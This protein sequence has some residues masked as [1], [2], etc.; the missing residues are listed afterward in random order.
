[1]PI[2]ML[3]VN[4]ALIV[5]LLSGS[6]VLAQQPDRMPAK[7]DGRQTGGV[8]KAPAAR[9]TQS[10]I[11]GKAV[12]SDAT[13]LPNATVRLRN[14]T[15]NEIEQVTATD[16]IGE[17]SFTVQPNLPY[18]VEVVDQAGRI[19]AVGNVITTQAGEVASAVVAIPTRLPTLAG[20]FGDTTASVVSAAAG[21]GVTL[22]DTAILPVLSATR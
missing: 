1:M 11:H 12:D 21:T 4:L 10:V 20:I 16:H 9:P 22:V 18:V 13:P 2:R 8:T 15:A 14:L 7:A 6:I 3:R 17:F 5:T 19:M